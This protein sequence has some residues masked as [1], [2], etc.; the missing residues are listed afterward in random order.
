MSQPLTTSSRVLA[1]FTIEPQTAQPD[2]VLRVRL[3]G[4]LDAEGAATL[5]EFL[6][7]QL[8]LGVRRV[9]LDFARVPFISSSGVGSLISSVGAY[10]D[11]G[12]DIV[13][14]RLSA[15]LQSVLKM[16]DLLDYVTIARD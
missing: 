12:G 5:Q 3:R 10:R 14:R 13:L 2:A 16:L 7:A 9:E 1:P 11:E 8:E 4:H 15:G 6:D